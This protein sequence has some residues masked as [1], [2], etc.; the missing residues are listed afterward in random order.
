MFHLSSSFPKRKLDR[1]IEMVDTSIGCDVAYKELERML[2]EKS[3]LVVVPVLSKFPFMSIH[4]C[5]DVKAIF[6]LESMHCLSLG[7]RRMLI[8][9]VVVML[10]EEEKTTSSL[11]IRKEMI[12]IFGKSRQRCS[13]S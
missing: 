9:C 6:R 5:V 12:D 10:G 3:M 11:G 13:Q 2:V 7:L 4:R 8:K 1:N